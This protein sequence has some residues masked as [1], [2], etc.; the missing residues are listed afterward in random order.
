MIR[1]RRRPVRETFSLDSF[2]DLVTN[3][4]GIII[5][6]I[7]VAWVGARSYTSLPELLKGM[8][9]GGA[10]TSEPEALPG[11][12]LQDE[13]AWQRQEIAQAQA[14]MLE[15]LR[16]LD[17]LKTN[18]QETE[19]Q[20]AALAAQRRELLGQETSLEKAESKKAQ[21]AHEAALS[22]ADV[23]KR[24]ERLAEELK[25][26]ETLP[27]LTKTLHY[28]TPVSQTVHA[29]EAHFEC[30]EGKVT[31]VNLDA[32]LHQVQQAMRDKEKLLQIQWEAADVTEPFGAFQMRYVIARYRSNF[33]ALVEPSSP[34]RR[35]GFSY[36]LAEWRIEP[37]DANRGEDARTA[38]SERS[39]FR[40][41]IDGLAVE[42][43]AVTLWV[44]PDSFALYRQLRDYLTDRGLTV[45]GRPLPEG[46]HI[47][48]SPH[49]K[50][51]RGQ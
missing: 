47:S 13:L 2:L 46:A 14:R 39:E 23:Q 28:R 48:G 29:N 31:F 1:R 5:R 3:V 26:L 44:Y 6:L 7:L 9:A 41:V 20:L 35:G 10:E 11:D 37:L 16:Q 4:V 51:S 38:M 34:D 18:R 19:Q 30:R 24:R 43:A 50:K 17:L 40:H 12:P 8:H 33:E 21:V 15:Q 45:A 49:G 27:T 22:L 25:K 36:G 32:M 42:K